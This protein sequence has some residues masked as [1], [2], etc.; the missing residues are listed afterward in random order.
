MLTRR[1]IPC[2]DTRDGR[3]VKGRRFRDL[4]DVGSP[5]E[6]ATQYQ[7][8]GADEIVILDVVATDRH[9]AHAL[10][11][12]RDVRRELALPLTVGGG[13]R[14]V[15]DA[16]RLLEAGADKIGVN[17]AALI[18][19]IL[20]DELAQEFGCQ[21][22][23]LAIDAAQ[24]GNGWQVFQRS[25]SEATGRDAVAWANEAAAR[26]AGEILLTSIDRDGT[27]DGYDLRL[28]LAVS[29]A[30]RVPVIAS[31][32]ARTVADLAAALEA[33]ADAVLAASMFHDGDTSVRAVKLALQAQGV[34]I[35]P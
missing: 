22:V 20:L 32:G 29:S 33:G 7:R 6:L 30:V 17:T 4:R 12:V 11:A 25:G 13:V 9:R 16:S 27:R 23:T 5:A 8:D 31:G 1:I 18:R 34:E 19:P 3:V 21:C 15:I 14:S 28:T 24:S 35:R 2:L 26:G 10:E